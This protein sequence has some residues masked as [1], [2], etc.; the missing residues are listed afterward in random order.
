[1]N[2]FNHVSLL[3]TFEQANSLNQLQGS[4]SDPSLLWCRLPI[5]LVQEILLIAASE[6]L[7]T[8]LR[9]C[10]V[11]HSVRRIVLPLLYRSVHLYREQHVSSFALAF[12]SRKPSLVPLPSRITLR[13]PPLAPVRALALSI[14]HAL[15]SLESALAGAAAAGAFDRTQYLAISAPL[16]GAHAFWLRSRQ[17]AP[18]TIMLFHTGRPQ[19]VDFTLPIFQRVHTLYTSTLDGRRRLSISSN[20]D[21]DTFALTALPALRR[22]AMTTRAE[23]GAAEITQFCLNVRKVLQ[24][25]PQLE[26]VVV[27]LLHTTHASL[28]RW[29]MP[30]AALAREGGARLKVVGFAP[31]AR[32]EWDAFTSP[33][34]ASALTAGMSPWETSTVYDTPWPAP[35]QYDDWPAF[36]AHGGRGLRRAEEKRS[37]GGSHVQPLPIGPQWDLDVFGDPKVLARPVSPTHYPGVWPAHDDPPA[38][39]G[40]AWVGGEGPWIGGG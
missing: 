11:A 34:A 13:P 6:S 27:R 29:G 22:L 17:I 9:F 31:T 32:I 19:A 10:L 33:Y 20:S 8:A 2:T 7:R 21:N 3:S 5:E 37:R 4:S 25:L 26:V 38:A 39:P 16:L 15:P 14:P 24:K 36:T 18:T 12:A 23:R 40:P 28:A 30:L 1:M 35:R